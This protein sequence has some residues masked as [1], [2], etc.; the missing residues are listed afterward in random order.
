MAIAFNICT[1]PVED[2]TFSSFNTP[3]NWHSTGQYFH[4]NY[5]G[6]PLKNMGPTPEEFCENESFTPREFYL[7]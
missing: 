5:M 7:F 3:K 4:N 6:L 2:L 1:P